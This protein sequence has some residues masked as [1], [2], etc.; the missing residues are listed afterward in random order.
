MVGPRPE[1][2][3]IVEKYG[4]VEALRLLV[5]PGVTGLWQL[6][7]S[8]EQFIHENIHYDLEY[9]NNRSLLLDLKILV[10]TILF[11]LSIRNI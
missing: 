10:K 7:G 5:N 6:Y 9:V 11:V 3:F 4:P 2:P 8:R 1:M